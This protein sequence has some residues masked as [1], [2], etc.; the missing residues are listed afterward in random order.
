M[1]QRE[2]LEQHTGRLT[3]E[4]WALLEEASYF[5]DAERGAETLEQLAARVRAVLGL[6][7]PV[8]A[9]GV[10]QRHELGGE[11][12]EVLSLL[13]ATDAARDE[14]VQVFRRE[15]LKGEPVSPE[16][17][18]EWVQARRDEPTVWL[19]VPVAASR[20]QPQA[21]G[22]LRISPPLDADEQLVS[23]WEQRRLQFLDG[24]GIPDSVAT[25]TG[26]TLEELRS[27]GEALAAGYGWTP[28]QATV[29]VLTDAVPLLEEIHVQAVLRHHPAANR[30]VLEVDPSARPDRVKAAYQEQ[31]AK[32]LGRKPQPLGEKALA[33]A[34]FVAESDPGSTWRARLDAWNLAYPDWVYGP[35]GERNFHRDA[36]AAQRRLLG[37]LPIVP[38]ATGKEGDDTNG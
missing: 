22:R 27:L 29:F 1:I 38:P 5:R 15:R 25:T 26:G 7:E 2:Q 32:L 6:S 21:D 24:H 3:D 20:L 34:R 11:R 33:L 14:R 13:L 28:A 37:G 9:P 31:R 35:D 10:K 4:Q 19:R 16:T 17:V 12:A 36:T 8:R 30:I 23:S 18:A